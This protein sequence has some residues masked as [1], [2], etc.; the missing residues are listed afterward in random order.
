MLHFRFA[1]LGVVGSLV[2]AAL[3]NPV[4]ATAQPVIIA[5]TEGW[6]SLAP[7]I[8]PGSYGTLF[9][10]DLA[11]K[12]DNGPGNSKL[13]V[14]GVSCSIYNVSPTIIG[15]GMPSQIPVGRATVVV[16]NNGVSSAP[17]SITLDPYSPGIR[18]AY[19]DHIVGHHPDGSVVTADAP[20]TPG[21][22][23]TIQATGLG[24]VMPPPPPSVTL[25]GFPAKVE[26]VIFAHPENDTYD[27]AI[28]IPARLQS[29][30]YVVILTIAGVSSEPIPVLQVF[31]TG[32]VLSQSGVTFRAVAGSAT[33]LQQSSSVIGTDKVISWTAS[34]ST[35][36]GGDWLQVTPAN[37]ISDPA[38]SAPTIQIT[39]SA[40]KLQPGDYYGLVTIKPVDT[41]SSQIISV[42]LSVLPPAQSPGATVDPT[43]VLFVG[44]PGGAAPAAQMIQVNNPTTVALAFSTTTT[45]SSK[46][47]WFNYQP[48]TGTVVPGQPV[49]VSVQPVTSLP[50]GIYSGSISFTFSD[51]KTRVVN[52][53]F[54]VAAGVGS[55]NKFSDNQAN[56]PMCIP[57]KLFPVLTLL[58]AN[59]TS[60]VA[61]PT[62]I[63]ASIVDDCATPLA[64]GSVIASFSN[65]DEPIALLSLQGG[66]WAGTWIPSHPLSSDLAVIL[67]AQS[68]SPPLEGT[69]QVSGSAPTNPNIPIIS[70]GGVVGTASY[71]AS[72][73]P[74]TMISVFGTALA[75]STV[76]A[77]LI[78]L[79]NTLATAS[80][81]MGGV[82]LPL[83]YV[84]DR[85]VNAVLPYGIATNAKYQVIVQ[86][87]GAL[88][89]PETIVVLDAQP[90]VFTADQSG[91][92]QGSIYKIPSGGGQ[93][94][95]APGAPVTAGDVLTVYC[96]GLG[97]VNPPLEAGTPAPMNQL[98]HT[99]NPVAAT[100]G[101]VD[102]TVLF[103]GLTPGFAGLYQINLVVPPGVSTGDAVT[104]LIKVAGQVSVPVTLAVQ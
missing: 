2:L 45:F 70:S 33:L 60:P 104:L 99:A 3:V 102:A 11:D 98:E 76:Q 64:I 87:G 43:G 83:I 88:S 80:I 17:F 14:N 57:T 37:G 29:G 94:L 16:S 21:E 18:G 95:A 75:E 61:W 15:F 46:S 63:E 39:A 25:G 28:A 79:P 41:N 4:L 67:D 90:G 74:G 59:F 23:I 82:Q 77:S 96:A 55:T 26:S 86:R 7:K 48:S 85:Q 42:V 44:A 69:V 53:L 49:I 12:S 66:R 27:V 22:K 103:A 78:P 31:A 92:G 73:S 13:F 62:P 56:A 50:V 8:S 93:I 71:A 20:A 1:T 38:Q 24:A 9:G 89:T 54:V 19:G 32:L 65:G 6:S 81:F 5:V 100:I 68:L 72:P 52:L 40:A 34:P 101:G 58:G 84:S 47:S 30:T 35:I 97:E 51:G 91:K 36:S 10:T